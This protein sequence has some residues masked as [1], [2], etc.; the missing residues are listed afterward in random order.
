MKRNSVSKRVCRQGCSRLNSRSNQS[1][2]G[3]N[4]P[5]VAP[6]SWE[7]N[8]CR[9]PKDVN[10]SAFPCLP[11]ASIGSEDY[12][13]PKPVGQKPPRSKVWV[14]E[15]LVGM[16]LGTTAGLGFPFGVLLKP[17]AKWYPQKD[18]KHAV[19]VK[20]GGPPKCFFFLSPFGVL[21]NPTPHMVPSTKRRAKMRVG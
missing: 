20:L 19:R 7:Q 18:S 16:P 5:L 3:T 8:F 4:F 2:S 17:T 14:S 13:R 21:C 1:P 15:G 6:E 11:W 9:P 12:C 10:Y